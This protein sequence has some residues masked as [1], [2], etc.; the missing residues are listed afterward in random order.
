MNDLGSYLL[1]ITIDILRKREGDEY[2][3]DKILD[4]AANKGTGKWATVSIANSGEPA[5]MMPAA[6]FARYLSFFKEKREAA[7]KV[8][9]YLCNTYTIYV[10]LQFP[11]LT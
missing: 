11:A 5:T 10:F 2:L 9:Q 8:L 4:K 1:G 7:A 6:L 3:L